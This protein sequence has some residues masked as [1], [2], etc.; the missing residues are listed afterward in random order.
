MLT[1]WL[2]H[3]S[4]LLQMG[5]RNCLEA[6]WIGF[7]SV[8]DL[9]YV[10]LYLAKCRSSPSSSHCPQLYRHGGMLEI[11]KNVKV[12]FWEESRST[13]S[14]YFWVIGWYSSDWSRWSYHTVLAFSQL[15]LKIKNLHFWDCWKMSV[16]LMLV[17]LKAECRWP[18]LLRK[19]RELYKT[20]TPENSKTK[21]YHHI[22]LRFIWVVWFLNIK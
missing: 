22:F 11:W 7:D 13:F 4:Q 17:C 20:R 5:I 18:K 16:L 6:G 19:G 8:Q 15:G 10:D 12:H 2:S 9:E 21:D 3:R 14:N 1:E